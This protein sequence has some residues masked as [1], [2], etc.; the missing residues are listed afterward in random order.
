VLI[1]AEE[2]EMHKRKD[3]S[4]AGRAGGNEWAKH[5]R[6]FG[7]RSVAKAERIAAKVQIANL[8]SKTKRGS[9]E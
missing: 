8:L 5:L 2:R 6:P 3:T 9:D 7:K 4:I 1:W